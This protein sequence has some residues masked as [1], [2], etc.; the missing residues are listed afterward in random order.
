MII[1]GEVIFLVLMVASLLTLYGLDRPG[2]SSDPHIAWYM[3]LTTWTT[4]LIDSVFFMSTSGHLR[5]TAARVVLLVLFTARVVL[6]F[7]LAHMVLRGRYRRRKID[8]DP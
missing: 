1:V 3:T 8:E 6:A 4:L 2:H 7:W 5:G